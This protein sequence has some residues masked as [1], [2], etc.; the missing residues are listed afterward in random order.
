MTAVSRTIAGRYTL[1]EKL[2]G[3]GTAVLWRGEDGQEGRQV[4]IRELPL[5][6]HEPALAERLQREAQV[7]VD[8]PSVVPVHDVVIADGTA[9]L[10]MDLV[11][12]R[13]LEDLASAGPLPPR[14][15]AEI[16]RQVLGALAAAHAAG[17]V[18]GDVRPANILVSDDGTARLTGFGIAQ[19]L[20]PTGSPAFLAPERIAGHEGTPHSDLWSLGV[21][22]LSAAEGAT[23][24]Q[25]ANV[26]ATLYAVVNEQPPFTRTS[27]PLADVLRGLLAK[28]PSARMLPDHAIPMLAL[29]A[30][31]AEAPVPILPAPPR[32]GVSAPSVFAILAGVAGMVLGFALLTNAMVMHQAY[33]FFDFSDL[34]IMVGDLGLILAGV[35]AVAGGASLLAR[36]QA[37]QIMLS[38]SGLLTLISFGLLTVIGEDRIHLG[39]AIQPGFTI[40][41]LLLL[42]AA[43]LTIAVWFVPARRT[44][45]G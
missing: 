21:T 19:A 8:H 3:D 35:A 5:P 40:D 38:V 13:T 26:A 45:V 15:V 25:R 44:A 11:D 42:F 33:Y 28:A 20:D 24:F 23:F 10:V 39:L 6:A 34:S 30:N 31:G 17:V 9:F 14:L 41:L 22:L 37:G 16:G 32:P 2:G 4:A 12:A 7:V 43:A 27:G 36:V 29:A 18:H 1:L